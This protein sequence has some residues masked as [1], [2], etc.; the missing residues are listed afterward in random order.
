LLS[1]QANF[2]V[3]YQGIVNHPGGAFQMREQDDDVTDGLWVFI[4]NKI[5]STNTNDL[6]LEVHNLTFVPDK[7][8]DA[9]SINIPAG[10]VPIEIIVV[11]CAQQIRDMDIELK[12]NGGA[13][14]LVG[15]APTTSTINDTL[16]PPAL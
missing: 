12:L 9:P 4:Q 5:G 13:Y 11:R 2:F 3:H 6:F 1:D 15:N 8:A 10:P 16:F 7:T 14:Q